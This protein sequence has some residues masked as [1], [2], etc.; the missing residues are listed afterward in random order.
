MTASVLVAYATK[1]GS[2]LEV[3]E[4]IA[5]TLR[6]DGLDVD[7]L[8]AKDVRSLD[9]YRA[10]ILGAPLYLARWHKDAR[11][12]LTR[13][14]KALVQLQVA[15][16]ALGPWKNEEKELISAREELN[17]ELMKFPWLRP[18]ESTV[19]VGKFDP[20]KLGFPFNLIKPLREIP[21]NDGRDWDLIRAWAREVASNLM[22]F[23]KEG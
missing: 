6:E 17:K 4:A 13:H 11:N 15:T 7:F 5:Q 21:A 18:A 10:V 23:Q 20:S 2:T 3:A 8:A 22:I 1:Y 14:R 12:F 9:G 19:F 16:F